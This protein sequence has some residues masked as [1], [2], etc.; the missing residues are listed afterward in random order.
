MNISMRR[1]RGRGFIEYILIIAL[2]YVTGGAFSYTMYSIQIT[3]FFLVATAIAFYLGE[4]RKLLNEKSFL[5]LCSMSFFLILVPVLNGDGLS[6]YIAIIMQLFI[7]FF[8]ASI[9]GPHEFCRKYV[10]VIIF[11]AAVSLVGF[12]FGA[13]YPSIAQLF[14]LTIGG[15]GASV[16]YYNAG[17]YVFM[18]PKGYGY[19]SLTTRNAGICWEPGCY[20]CFLNIALMMLLEEKKKGDVYRFYLKFTILVITIFT[21]FSTTGI[22]ILGMILV[23][24][25]NEWK[26]SSRV[27]GV[28]LPMLGVFVAVYVLAATS[29]GQRIVQKITSEIITPNEDGQNFFSRLSLGHIKYLFEGSFWFFGMSFSRWLSF[30]VKGLWNSIIHSFLCLGTPFTLIQMTGY[31]KGSRVLVK[32]GWLL[33]IIMLMSAS[34]ETLYWRVFFN[35]IAACGWMYHR[36]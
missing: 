29:A 34:T 7:G 5:P 32:N 31:M 3:V 17:I 23:V 6:S 11:F 12:A 10:K 9:L 4:Y 36:D 20:Q 21:T 27:T 19:F 15:E 16:D 1:S 24:Y 14:P 33:F 35:T 30:G 28:M 18:Q 2:Y 26:G 25:V 13:M 22:I 8:I